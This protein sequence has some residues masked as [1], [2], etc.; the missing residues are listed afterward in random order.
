MKNL[1]TSYESSLSLQRKSLLSTGRRN[2]PLS[3]IQNFVFSPPTRRMVSSTC[4]FWLKGRE[5]G[6]EGRWQGSKAWAPSPSPRDIRGW[7][8]YLQEDARFC[9]IGTRGTAVPTLNTTL[10]SSRFEWDFKR[11]KKI[12]SVSNRHIPDRKPL[13]PLATVPIHDRV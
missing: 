10:A 12:I 1:I 7:N 6:E 13:L 2:L 11:D 8:S 5:G 9:L 4:L 3:F